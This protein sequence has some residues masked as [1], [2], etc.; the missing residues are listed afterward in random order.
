ML[1]YIVYNYLSYVFIGASFVGV[2]IT[3]GAMIDISTF[4]ENQ[5]FL[6]K[7]VNALFIF[8]IMLFFIGLLLP[9]ESYFCNLKENHSLNFCKEKS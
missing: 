5:Q 6:Q 9:R 8:F 3:I 4:Y 1:E 2:A 7:T